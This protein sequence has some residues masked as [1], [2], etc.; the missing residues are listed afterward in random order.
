MAQVLGSM[1]LNTQLEVRF[2]ED[3]RV[4]STS[5]L[6]LHLDSALAESV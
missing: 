2:W 3:G 1:I 5:N 4:G 6:S